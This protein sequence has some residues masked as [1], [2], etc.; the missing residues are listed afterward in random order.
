M[1]EK[2]AAAKKP[3][4]TKK[5]APVKA[6]APKRV[7]RKRA[8]K[9]V[10]ASASPVAASSNGAPHRG[11]RKSKVGYVVSAKT[12][13]TAIVQVSRL[14]Q[15]PLYKKVIRVRKRFPAHDANG[16]VKA[17]DIVRI[18]ESRPFSATK[19][20]QVVE[21]ISRAGEAGAAA[22]QVADVERLLE[23]TEGVTELLAKPERVAADAAAEE[24]DDAADVSER[25]G[26]DR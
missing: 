19:R 16:D 23:E 26:D 24:A 6:A 1:P 3:A 7:V 12:P 13:K 25:T 17:G 8:E 5:A 11:G 4:A 18:Q 14:R 2:K 15:H 9:P 22:P 10:A 21:V 20:W